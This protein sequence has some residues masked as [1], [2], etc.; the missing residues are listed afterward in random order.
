MNS[1]VLVKAMCWI[2]VLENENRIKWKGP[3]LANYCL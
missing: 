3:G 1:E 2:K